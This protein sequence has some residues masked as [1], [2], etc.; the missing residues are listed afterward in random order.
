MRTPRARTTD[1]KTSHD[2]AE[3]VREVTATQDYVLRALRRPRT[4]VELVE[5]YRNFKIAPKASE[6]GLRT[7]RSEL[8]RQGLVRDSGRR[9]VLDSG[10][11]AIVWEKSL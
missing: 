7:R 8:V 6:S 2:A 4:D 10:R 3:S 11:A 9:V 1:P 5:A